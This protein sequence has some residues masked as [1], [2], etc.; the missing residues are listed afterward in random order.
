MP[1]VV[2][3]VP[4]NKLRVAYNDV[5]DSCCTDHDGVVRLDFYT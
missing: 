3:Y 1:T 2:S 4:V 5:L